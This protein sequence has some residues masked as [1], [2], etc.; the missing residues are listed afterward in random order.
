MKLS[1]IQISR[2][3]AEARRELIGSPLHVL[4]KDESRKLVRFELGSPGNMMLDYLFVPGESILYFH[5]GENRRKSRHTTNF[6]PQLV[7]ATIRDIAQIN[8]DRIVRIDLDAGERRYALVFELFGP[9]GNLYMLG[10]SEEIITALKA[11]QVE[12]IYDP[13]KPPDGCPPDQIDMS[14]VRQ[15]LSGREDQSIADFLNSAIRGCDNS[16]WSLA[17]R[18]IKDDTTAGDL[19]DDELDTIASGIEQTCHSCL[20]G[21]YHLRIENN[22]LS[23]T[24]ISEPDSGF[25]SVN[26]ALAHAGTALGRQY[27]VRSI[28][29]R[30]SHGI[31]SNRKRLESKHAKLEKLTQ[32][33]E[34]AELYK[35]WAELLTINIGKLRKGM[36][37]VI[38]AD[39][40]DENQQEIAIPLQQDLSPSANIRKL[41][42]RFRKLTDGRDA[43]ARQMRI[44]NREI[45]KL[46]SFRATLE[47]SE[48]VGDLL[49][50]ERD[51]IREGY[52][53]K[54]KTAAGSHRSPDAPTFH[55]REYTTRA[56]EIVL[57]GRNAKENDYVTFTASRKYDIWFHS[58]QSPGSHVILRVKDRNYPPSM[59]SIL[60]AARIAA[61]YSQ[62]RNSEKVPIIYTETRHLQKIRGALG[63]VRYTRVKSIMVEPGLPSDNH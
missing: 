7:G 29:Q 11:H 50:L 38:V 37:S 35:K 25:H 30:I 13:P 55:P 19:D 46:E 31:R 63:K 58:Q 3:V 54:K 62:A 45:E 24:D 39:A 52:L 15:S 33:A 2:W 57:V 4:T 6:L 9:A 44:I 41:F 42:K 16:F 43:S 61:H 12:N 10:D 22:K 34:G 17:L 49:E 60:T 28:R 20:D 26:D 1:A 51:V 27:A 32:E 56:G 23:W 21:D 47:S 5:E 8:F 18:N 40:Y 14:F 59:E 36:T 53:K 48:N